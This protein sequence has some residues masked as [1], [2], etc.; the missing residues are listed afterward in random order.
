MVKLKK[1]IWPFV[2][3]LLVAIIVIGCVSTGFNATN[4]FPIPEVSL[5]RVAGRPI[6]RP[7]FGN[8]T[9]E[10]LGYSQYYDAY[11]GDSKYRKP[12]VVI[13]T[14]ESEIY[15]KIFLCNSS[16]LKIKNI[17]LESSDKD[18][19]I[20]I[21]DDYVKL[22]NVDEV[23]WNS[24]S[25]TE[26]T[27]KLKILSSEKETKITI[28]NINY[29]SSDNVEVSCNLNNVESLVVVKINLITFNE[30]ENVNNGTYVS[31][32][33]NNDPLNY[34]IKNEEDIE[35]INITFNN[36]KINGDNSKNTVNEDSVLYSMFEYFL[37][38]G[39]YVLKSNCNVMG[40]YCYY[41][42][43][44]TISNLTPTYSHNT[45]L[46]NCI[47][48]NLNLYFNFN[49]I[50]GLTSDY[51]YAN[52]YE[53]NE[54]DSDNRGDYLSYLVFARNNDY[55]VLDY[56][57]TKNSN[58]LD[59]DK[60]YYLQIVSEDRYAVSAKNTVIMTFKITNMNVSINNYVKL[61]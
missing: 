50:N 6:D 43:Y 22:E 32:N 21:E 37:Q 29:I 36:I 23:E 8:I 20:F 33:L 58:I 31:F 4:T 53:A 42:Q 61:S 38:P 44:F 59:N 28:K 13:D 45:E 9:Y 7:N 51:L 26:A 16:N 55:Y 46:N 54:Y 56:Y 11:E 14:K 3:V 48:E 41:L 24:D 18:V 47:D 35:I 30:I 52:L 10:D 49:G 19:M 12:Y 2:F 34:D 15:F 40:R 5:E 17:Q 57:D 60:T 39:E 27:Y 25:S 1:I